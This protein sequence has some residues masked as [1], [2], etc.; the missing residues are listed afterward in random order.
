MDAGGTY[1]LLGAIGR[2]FGWG[3]NIFRVY[4]NNKNLSHPFPGHW[5]VG[6]GGWRRGALDDAF[7]N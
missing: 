6:Q 7:Y 4:Y 1:S 5:G 2:G 3:K